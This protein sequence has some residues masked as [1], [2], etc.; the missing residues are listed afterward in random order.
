MLKKTTIISFF[1]LSLMMGMAFFLVFRDP[2]S[3]LAIDKIL[4]S[5]PKEKGEIAPTKQMRSG[6]VKELWITEGDKR[7]HYRIESPRSVLTALPKGNTFE[8][9]EQMQGIK[10]FFQEKIEHAEET[11]ELSQQLRFIESREGTYTYADHRFNAEQVFLALFRL[12]GDRLETN[13]DLSTAFLKGVAKEVTLS[14]S[15][16]GPSFHAKK[17]KAH[18]TTQGKMP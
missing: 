10:C 2:S 17:F 16:H 1:L 11:G 7:L 13:L 15:H 3:S 8:L 6:V 4:C 18:I 12:P 5:A 9:T 14:L